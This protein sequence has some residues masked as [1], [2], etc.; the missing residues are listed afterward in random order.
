[1]PILV[2]DKGAASRATV[3]ALA[4]SV[5]VERARE[6]RACSPPEASDESAQLCATL[7][8]VR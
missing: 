3:G 8:I 4:T 6:V 2:S 1:M 7:G 5:D